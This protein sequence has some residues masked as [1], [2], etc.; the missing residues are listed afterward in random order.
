MEEENA[1][2]LVDVKNIDKYPSYEVPSS[3]KI[4]SVSTSVKSQQVKSELKKPTY[5]WACYTFALVGI[6]LVGSAAF[7][8]LAISLRNSNS[9]EISF[10]QDNFSRSLKQLQKYHDELQENYSKSS[11]E[12]QHYHDELET[13]SSKLLIQFQN[14]FQM[15]YSSSLMQLQNNFDELQMNY[16]RSL[17][18][19]Q[20][21]IDELQYNYSR[22]LMQLQNDYSRLLTQLQNELQVNNSRSLMQLQNLVDNS[23]ELQTNNSR[24]LMQLQNLVD[25]NFELQTNSS[26]SLDSKINTL[27]M[28]GKNPSNPVASCCHVLLLNLSSPSGHYWIRS[29]NG[30][31]VRWYCDFNGQYADNC[32]GLIPSNLGLNEDDPASSCNTLPSNSPSGYYWIRTQGSPVRVYCNM[33]TASVNLTRGWM[34]VAYIDMRNTSHQCPSGLTLLS[35][36][37]APRRACDITTSSGCV[38]S[39]FSVHGVEYSHV[40]GRIIAYQNSVPIAFHFPAQNAYNNIDSQYVFGVSL[41]HGQSPRNHIWTFA[42]ASDETS[43]RPTFK[44]P[45]INT[46]ITPSP[47]V[48]DFIGN[49]YF[50]DTALSTNYANVPRAF[51]P[52]DPLWDGEGCGP[53][54]VCCSFNHPP[55]FIKHLPSPT[56]DD[57]EMRVCRGDSSG[58]TPFEIVEL[59]VQ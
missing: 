58:S 3:N 4:T 8:S 28:I 21:N 26:R 25:H 36:N 35:R 27:H 56:T 55:W 59:Y 14:E 50:C 51:Q 18:Q 13:N 1:Y 43:N 37:S 48:P 10:M 38:S 30:S 52:A 53:T 6:I 47:S 9:Y 15:N 46:G 39:I 54:N 31:A 32:N 45:C 40:Y 23:L 22:S 41:T 17:M 33:N 2:E 29:S 34:R 5:S 12:H 49:D 7:A 44:C 16:S 42:G 57:V 24:S 11:V 20:N 19:L